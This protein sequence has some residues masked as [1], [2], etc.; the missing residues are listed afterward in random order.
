M[1]TVTDDNILS[2]FKNNPSTKEEEKANL[3]SNVSTF[4]KKGKVKN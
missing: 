2:Y 3:Y 4:L 1:M